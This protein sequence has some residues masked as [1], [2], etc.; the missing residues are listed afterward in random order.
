MKDETYY[1]VG[2]RRRLRKYEIRKPQ[3][4]LVRIFGYRPWIWQQYALLKVEQQLRF[5]PGNH[6]DFERFNIP[7][8]ARDLWFDWLH[9]PK[10][11]DFK[12][13]SDDPRINSCQDDLFDH[14]MKPF[15]FLD[16]IRRED[17]WDFESEEVSIFTYWG[18][19]GSGATIC[20]ICIFLQICIPLILLVN[21]VS[22]NMDQ[23]QVSDTKSAWVSFKIK[24]IFL[25]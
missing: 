16:D 19:I 20:I 25:R 5:Q 4:G 23:G 10:N 22:E 9:N 2:L 21:T 17:D 6:H 12:K 7:L 13:Y 11:E 18:L 8:F 1:D 24:I 3:E 14:I 15:H